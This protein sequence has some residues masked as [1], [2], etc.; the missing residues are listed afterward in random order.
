MAPPKSRSTVFATALLLCAIVL[1]L[2]LTKGGDNTDLRTDAAL[3]VATPR[4][5][6]SFPHSLD[7]PVMAGANHSVWEEDF[8][9]RLKVG[10][11]DKH[12]LWAQ[13]ILREDHYALFRSTASML[14]P[15]PST[16]ILDVGS[17]CGHTED[18]IVKE[19]GSAVLGV[20][21]VRE[22]VEH[23][24]ERYAGPR[25]KFCQGDVVSISA[26]SDRSF[27][28]I[29]TIAVFIYLSEDEA[30]KAL[31]DTAKTLTPGGV[32]WLGWMFFFPNRPKLPFWVK[33]VN[34]WNDPQFW[35]EVV[36]EKG[37]SLQP[38]FE[39]TSSLFVHRRCPVDEAPDQFWHGC[40]FSER[41]VYPRVQDVYSEEV[42]RLKNRTDLINQGP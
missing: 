3:V 2:L 34:G 31:Y 29:I 42:L 8:R 40:W 22:L 24:K 30:C 33:C 21:L 28:L 27:D 17:G 37:R 39:W 9:Q 38:K 1:Y 19:Y 23:A 10:L 4:A 7:C 6:S 26:F 13:D 16:K 18:I 32:L 11:C 20:E 15:T 35:L 25:V 14:R 36:P 12:G 5:A 41:R